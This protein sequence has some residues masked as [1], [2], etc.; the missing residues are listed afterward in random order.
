MR[1]EELAQ[2]TDLIASLNDNALAGLIMYLIQDTLNVM[3]VTGMFI[4]LIIATYK[5]VLNNLSYKSDY[6]D[7]YNQREIVLDENR[8]NH[9][10]IARALDIDEYSSHKEL[11]DYIKSLPK[12]EPKS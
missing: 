9:I 8:T 5:L 1:T 6:E 10:E 2:V 7:M 11:V 4:I 3:I 12:L